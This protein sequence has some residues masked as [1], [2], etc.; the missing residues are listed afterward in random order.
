MYGERFSSLDIL[1]ERDEEIFNLIKKEIDKEECSINLIAS[2]NIASLAVREAVRSILDNKYAEGYIN[3]RFFGG[4]ENIDRIEELAINR[5]KE[6]FNCSYVNVQPYSGSCANMG[7][8]FALLE[9]KDFVLGLS[10][11]A[12]GHITHGSNC[13]I[14]GKLY[15]FISYGLDERTGLIDY[16]ELERLAKEKK[17]KMIVAGASAYPRIIDFKKIHN[18]AKEVGAYFMVDIA[19]IAGLICANLYPS[20]LE[21]CDVVTST[22]NKTLRGPRSGLVLCNNYEIAKK[23]DKAIFPGLQGGPFMQIIA[24]VA[25]CFREALTKEFKEYQKDILRNSK[26][27]ADEL[28]NRGFKLISNGTDVHFSLIDLTEFKITGEEMQKRLELINIVVNKNMIFNDR[29]RPSI[30]SGIRVGTPLITTRGFKEN[31]MK[32]IAEC[33]YLLVKDFKENKRKCL[34]IVRRLVLKYPM[35]N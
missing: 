30:A 14:S 24:G 35:F 17:P 15:N 19:H 10:L 23:I 20:P 13:N 27:L 29:N 25:V 34:E 5:A 32:E 18:I 11:S 16:E 7:V 4:C 2:E 21:Y 1:K 3:N 28:M 22:T 31:D 9:P 12:G 6:L 8:Y 33:I 26:R